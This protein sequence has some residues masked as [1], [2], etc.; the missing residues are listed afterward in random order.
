MGG[1]PAHPHDRAVVE[2]GEHA[3]QLVNRI[4]EHD[5]ELLSAAF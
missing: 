2:K 5:L 4:G 1:K 3:H